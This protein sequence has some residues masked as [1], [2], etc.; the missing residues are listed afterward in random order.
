MRVT[1]RELRALPL[2]ANDIYVRYAWQGYTDGIHYYVVPAAIVGATK[3]LP[4]RCYQEERA[5]FR[6]Q[7]PRFPASQRAAAMAYAQQRFNPAAAAGVSL[8]T[9]GGGVRSDSNQQVWMLAELHS[10][11]AFGSAGGGGTDTSTTIARLV[12]D[13]V[14]SVTAT[15]PAQTYPGRVARTLAVTKRPLR[16]L[17][18]FH[19]PGASVTPRLTFRSRTGKVIGQTR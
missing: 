15:Y 13:D 18:I 16:N 12:P 19:L 8:V 9:V 5:A 11:P 3:L 4:A 17:V 6:K 2:I 1:V 14:A 10:N 7:A